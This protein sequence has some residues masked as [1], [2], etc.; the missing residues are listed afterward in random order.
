MSSGRVNENSHYHE[1]APAG[2]PSARK[3]PLS[4]TWPAG[5]DRRTESVITVR[6]STP[7]TLPGSALNAVALRDLRRKRNDPGRRPAG[8]CFSGNAVLEWSAALGEGRARE[9]GPALLPAITSHATGYRTAAAPSPRSRGGPHPGIPAGDG[10]G[11]APPRLTMSTAYQP[12]GPSPG[13]RCLHCTTRTAQRGKRGLC[14]VCHRNRDVRRQ[15]RLAPAA[16][17]RRRPATGESASAPRPTNR[18]RRAPARRR[19]SWC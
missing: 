14:N 13:P 17:S 12:P 6:R 8:G 4:G 9:S 3:G 7:A 16:T 15:C 19:R 11:R 10:A 2:G 18:P 5:G 1:L